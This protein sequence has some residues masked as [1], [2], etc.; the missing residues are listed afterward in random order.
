MAECFR[1]AGEH[2]IADAFADI[3]IG[4]VD[5]LHARAAIDLYGERRHRFAHAEPQ[6]GDAGG[7]HFI[8]NDVD[9][10]ENDLIEGVRRERL[11]QQ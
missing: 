5:R 3:A 6:R 1:A 4:G 10:A 8:G 9:A 2:E 11:A 7:V